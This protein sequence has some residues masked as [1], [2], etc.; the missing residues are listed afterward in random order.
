MA[1]PPSRGKR[2]LQRYPVLAAAP[3]HE[4]PAIVRAALRNPLVLLLVFGAGL[5]LLPMYFD[6]VFAFLELAEEQSTVMA[7]AKLAGAVL[8][9]CLV[10]VPLLSRWVIPVFI[11]REMKKRGYPADGRPG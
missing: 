6:L 3:E 1:P 2:L 7:L 8:L 10:A 4:R 5:L 11:R 9:P